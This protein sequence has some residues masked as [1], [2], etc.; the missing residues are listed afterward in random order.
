MKHPPFGAMAGMMPPGKLVT[1]WIAGDN[2]K[3][4]KQTW[5]NYVVIAKLEMK[6]PTSKSLSIQTIKLTR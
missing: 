5:S 1:T 4:W 2:W 6:P 3:V